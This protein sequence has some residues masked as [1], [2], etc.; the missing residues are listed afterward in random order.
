M[1]F[2]FHL[3]GETTGM[4]VL[5]FPLKSF[6]QNLSLSSDVSTDFFP[7]LNYSF[8]LLTPLS[9]NSATP[10]T[11]LTYLSIDIISFQMLQRYSSQASLPFLNIFPILSTNITPFLSFPFLQNFILPFLS[12]LNL[13]Q[14]GSHA[15][16]T[17]AQVLKE[18]HNCQF[19]SFPP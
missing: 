7:R 4:N 14:S 11:P 10:I 6:L 18:L 3:T 12:F 9:H 8:V 17:D 19:N 13:L 2:I 16:E 5:N 1:D 15:N